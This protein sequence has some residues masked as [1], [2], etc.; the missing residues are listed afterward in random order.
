MTKL[1]AII[2]KYGIVLVNWD[3]NIQGDR[4]PTDQDFTWIVD[5]KQE[6]IS[7]LVNQRQTSWNTIAEDRAH[8]HHFIAGRIDDGNPDQWIDDREPLDGQI[9]AIASRI[10]MSVDYVRE[11]YDKSLLPPRVL[12]EE[13]QKYLDDQ[14][15]VAEM[16]AR[17]QASDFGQ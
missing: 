5:H 16:V 14:L 9:V 8:R 1:Q 10:G 4:Q 12:S 13:E 6:I 15:K 7:Y 2:D 11:C 3:K 17:M